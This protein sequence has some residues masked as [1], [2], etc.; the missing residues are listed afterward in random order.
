MRAH[1]YIACALG[2]VAICKSWARKLVSSVGLEVPYVGSVMQCCC[3]VE[4]SA[5]LCHTA[6]VVPLFLC[7]LCCPHG[8]DHLI[9]LVCGVIFDTV[10]GLCFLSLL[11]WLV[12]ASVLLLPVACACPGF[13][14]WLCFGLGLSSLCACLTHVF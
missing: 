2:V 4:V 12:P 11:F 13:C 10:P 9:A 1:L 6:L 3:P 7:G 14:W 8:S 5:C